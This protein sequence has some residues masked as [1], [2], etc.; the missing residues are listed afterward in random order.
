MF[1]RNVSMNV[2]PNSI[3]EFS[4]SFNTVILPLLRKQPGFC[5][6]FAYV[7]ETATHITGISMWESKEQADAYHSAG[8]PEVLKSLAS[9]IDGTPKVRTSSVSN[10]TIQAAVPAAA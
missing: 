5:E 1:V 4:K 10:S 9:V 7:N 3:E 2:K 8:Y 6:A